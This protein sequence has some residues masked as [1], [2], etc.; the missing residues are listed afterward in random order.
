MEAKGEKRKHSP[1]EWQ[2]LH[3]H[4]FPSHSCCL[5]LLA[6]APGAWHWFFG[7]VTDLTPLLSPSSTPPTSLPLPVLFTVLPDPFLYFN[8]LNR[9][10][11]LSCGILSSTN[12]AT[13]I[14]HVCVENSGCRDSQGGAVER[15]GIY[16]WTKSDGED[17][18]ELSM[19]GDYS[20]K[21]KGKKEQ[22][23]G[24]HLQQT[25]YNN[26]EM[27]TAKP[28]WRLPATP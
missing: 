5:L 14:T 6:L 19:F 24:W 4:S 28:T 13:E 20:K 27:F 10:V 2:D 15:G 17:K 11:V 1:C 18:I 8:L 26:P 12:E 25:M 3:S 22:R 16:V 7:W 9:L 21:Q 23:R